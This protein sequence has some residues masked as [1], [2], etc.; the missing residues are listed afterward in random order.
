MN[1]AE[2]IA[3][4]EAK[5]ASVSKA[6]EDIMSKA[7]E[8]GSTLDVEQQETY[9]GH[10]KD[11]EAI[12]EHL[13]RLY[14]L[15]KAQKKPAS[16]G[17]PQGVQDGADQ[18]GGKEPRIT[19]R[20]P[21]LPPGLR[22]ARVAR[23]RVLAKLDGM[24]VRE[25]AKREYP[26]DDRLVH[27]VV[28]KADVAAAQTGETGWAGALVGDTT[29][30]FADFAE[31]LRPMTILGQFGSNGVPSLRRVPFRVR[32]LSQTGG[33]SASWVGE[34]KSKPLTEG[35]FASTT[36]S[37]LKVAAIAVSTEEVI[38]DSSPS[39]EMLIRDDLARACAYK[40]DNDFI[41]PNVAA[42]AGVSPA[43]ITNGLTFNTY[44][45][46]SVGNSEANIRTDVRKVWNAFIAANNP[47]S[48]AVWVMSSQTAAA[49]SLLVNSLGQ[50]A[51]PNVTM[52][53][54]TFLSIPVI[55]SEHVGN[56]A[57]SPVDDTMSFVWLV[58]AADIYLADEGG[59]QVDM[60]REAS[61]EMVDTG[62]QSSVSPPGITA[63]S[64]VSMFQTNSVAFR[65]ERTINWSRRRTP[66]VVGLKK[67]AWGQ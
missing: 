10:S 39:A 52:R 64:M 12:D 19:V 18:R 6:M 29:T 32:L 54:G 63:T 3:A 51:F 36:L 21:K 56:Y 38:R 15:Q 48:Q 65:A 14:A 50:Q 30:A 42:S 2:Q 31:Y 8:E 60:S 22:F 11:V 61:L 44:L 25:I 23:C 53:G 59:V 7:G 41:N 62:T 43:S 27:D 57:E 13:K 55:T 34:G 26:N 58:N 5:R 1:I 4:F 35:V 9:D 17:E 45:F 66:S 16:V 46:D 28:M 49:L 47:P 20:S 37:P 24:D 67:V 33:L 40:L